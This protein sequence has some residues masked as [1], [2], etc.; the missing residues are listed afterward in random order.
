MTDPERIIQALE[1]MKLTPAQM[2]TGLNATIDRSF[3][4]AVDACIA[5]IKEL[6]NER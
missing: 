5:K 4:S 3:N 6:T 1:E 2:V